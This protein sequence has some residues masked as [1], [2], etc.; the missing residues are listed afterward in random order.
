MIQ[1][2]DPFTEISLADRSRLAIR[3]FKTIADAALLRGYYRMGGRT[4]STLESALRTLSPE[5]Y[6]CINDPKSIELKG[7]EY[8]ID[9]LPRGIEACHRIVMTGSEDYAGAS[10]EKIQPL[11]RRRLSYRI[12]PTEMSFVIT[13]GH[14]EIYDILTHV[15]FLYVEAKKVRSKMCDDQGY[16]TVEWQSLEKHLSCVDDMCGTDLDQALW[17]L[18]L[19]LL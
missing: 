9:R 19:L 12:S 16:I 7:L 11:K 1:Q 4:G 18:S 17:N 3:T 8:V 6:G 13:R 2:G 10:F 15:T 5:I 14:S